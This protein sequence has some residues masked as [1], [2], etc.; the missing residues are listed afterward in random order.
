MQELNLKIKNNQKILA[1]GAELDTTLAYYHQG[2]VFVSDNLGE[3]G[4][5]FSVLEQKVI[6]FLDQQ[7]GR[8]S[9]PLIPDCILTDLH[10]EYNSTKVGEKLAKQWEIP[11][12]K[13]QHHHAHVFSSMVENYLLD[14]NFMPSEIISIACDGT[15][16]GLDDTI[17][18]GEMFSVEM[19]NFAF[20]TP[21]SPPCQGGI[22]R[23]GHLEHQTLIGGQL[24]VEEPARM[25]MSI[26]AKFLDEQELYQIMDGFYEKNI[27]KLLNSQLNQNFN[28]LTTSSCARV[29]DAA[30]A[31]LFG[32]NER[33]FKHQAAKMLEDPPD[34]G[35]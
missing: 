9:D 10:P 20:D 5:D 23:I 34:R 19:R 27:F 35:G 3:S 1:L 29:L 32:C 11:H 31:L 13:V 21:P 18:G 2:K 17:W 6:E 28:C 4:N 22:K 25:L 8:G 15:G 16:Y 14:D 12:L 24:A 30:C 7:R 26:L 33:R